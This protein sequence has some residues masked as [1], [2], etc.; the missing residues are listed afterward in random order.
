M[1]LTAQG[2]AQTPVFD[3]TTAE[4]AGVQC[5]NC[6]VYMG[7]ALSLALNY[8]ASGAKVQFQFMLRGKTGVNINMILANPRIQSSPVIYQ[9]IEVLD[10]DHNQPDRQTVT[11]YL[12]VLF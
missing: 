2:V 3:L 11:V 6:W 9:L 5:S 4:V 7:S 8:T 1:S 10:I 12:F